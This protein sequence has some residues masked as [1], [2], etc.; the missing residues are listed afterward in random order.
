[1]AHLRFPSS[2]LIPA[3]HSVNPSPAAHHSL[4][5]DL[6]GDIYSLYKYAFCRVGGLR[7]NSFFYEEVISFRLGVCVEKADTDLVLPFFFSDKWCSVRA[8]LAPPG[9]TSPACFPLY[10]WKYPSIYF[11]SLNN[12]TTPTPT[13]SST[14]RSSLHPGQTWCQAGWKLPFITLVSRLGLPSRRSHI[15]RRTTRQTACQ[16]NPRFSPILTSSNRRS[17][18]LIQ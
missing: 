15:S 2:I 7:S 4:T 8:V 17:S 3:L 16:C 1:M 14:G 13:A 12:E 10:F 18:C 6:F 9:D 5:F 11:N